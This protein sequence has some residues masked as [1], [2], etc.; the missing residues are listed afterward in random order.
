MHNKNVSLVHI[1]VVPEVDVNLV[2]SSLQRKVTAWAGVACPEHSRFAV[3]PFIVTK[4]EGERHKRSADS[5]KA[6][7]SARADIYDWET[8]WLS[9]ML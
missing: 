3:A 7:N 1:Q 8:K 2:T 4:M 9:T 6:R 5:S